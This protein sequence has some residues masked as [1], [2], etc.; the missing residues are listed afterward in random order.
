MGLALGAAQG[1][2]SDADEEV[3]K[4]F[5]ELLLHPEELLPPPS[6]HLHGGLVVKWEY[7]QGRNGISEPAR[8]KQEQS[9]ILHSQARDVPFPG[10]E[11]AQRQQSRAE[12]TQGTLQHQLRARAKLPPLALNKF[13]PHFGFIVK[14]LILRAGTAG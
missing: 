1:D 7:L 6:E 13:Q 12:V 11:G 14:L 8:P 5:Q 3:P 9:G 10:P 2:I 4:A